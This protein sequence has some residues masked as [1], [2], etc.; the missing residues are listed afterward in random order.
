MRLKV[1]L[2]IV[3]FSACTTV[4]NAAVLLDRVVAIVNQEVVTW[5]ELYRDMEAEASQNVKDMSAADRLKALKGSEASFLDSLINF[6][7]QVQE[8]KN[9]GMGV[10]DA[11]LKEAIDG[12]KKK[13][14]MTDSTFNDSLK[15]EGF[16]LDGYKRRLREQI[17][18]GKAVTS[19]VRNKIL[20]TDAEVKKFLGHNKTY[21]SESEEGY[22]ISQ[23]FFRRPKD[24][25]EKGKIEEKAAEVLKKLKEGEKFQDLARTYSED[26]SASVG[27]D[28]GFLKKDQLMSEFSAV[29][30]K[31]KTGEVS[32]P[33]WSDRGLH[34]IMLTEKT[35]PKSEHEIMEEARK[36]LNQKVFQDKYAS[37]VK[38]LRE[39]AF[40]DIKL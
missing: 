12:I 10:S 18:V 28:L 1:M 39:Q 7:L 38:S 34:I 14:A 37:W 32:E 27:G 19:Q 26:P 2:L 33:F 30:S 6:K 21:A 15:K 3:L 40:V 13:Y 8:A 16:T 36:E 35:G 9:L 23:I 25:E 4:S 20:I 17:L 24:G 5:S 11:E 31:L 29:V 22:R